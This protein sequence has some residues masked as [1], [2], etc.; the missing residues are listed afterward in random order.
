MSVEL[1]QLKFKV[2]SWIRKN[3]NPNFKLALLRDIEEYCQLTSIIYKYNVPISEL[4][5]VPERL[6]FRS[7]NRKDMARMKDISL[8]LGIKGSKEFIEKANELN[9]EIKESV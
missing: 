2:Y 3:K 6:D 5:L 1:R 4:G 7:T 9:K 8:I